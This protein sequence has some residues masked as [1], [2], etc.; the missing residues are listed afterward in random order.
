[1]QASEEKV[2]LLLLV[3]VVSTV[4][5]VIIINSN[6][7]LTEEIGEEV[8][9]IALIDENRF[10]TIKSAIDTY[11]SN[12]KYQNVGHL[13]DILDTRY[14]RENNINKNN[15][16]DILEKYNSNYNVDLRRVYQIKK[17]DNIYV[18]YTRAKLVEENY[19]SFM[20]E[21]IK[22]VY[23]K[24]TLNENTLAFSIAPLSSVEYKSKVG[25][26]DG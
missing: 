7:K 21:F 26:L 9:V 6:M 25:E 12:V 14:V 3:I 11:V 2:F 1:M 10:L 19:N 4:I 8:E 18:Y 23:Y 17:Y 20:Q 16:F 24:V 15:I 13:L 5:I 22:D